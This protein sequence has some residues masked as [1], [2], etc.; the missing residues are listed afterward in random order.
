[1]A[2]T[3]KNYTGTATT[4]GATIYTVPAAT[5]A[6]ILGLNLA[7]KSAGSISVSVQL[8]GVYIV[9]DAPLPTSTALSVLDGKI[10]AEAGDN[11]VVTASVNSAADVIL[12]VMESS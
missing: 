1:M 9:K 7:N 10:V 2:N 12:S 6:V 8:S 4:T 5:S 11:I 3:F